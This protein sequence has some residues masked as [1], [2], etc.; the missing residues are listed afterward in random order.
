MFAG[1][2]VLD[3]EHHG[4]GQGRHQGL[5]DGFHPGGEPDKGAVQHPHGVRSDHQDG[6]R[7][8]GQSPVQAVQHPTPRPAAPPPYVVV[9]GHPA[10][11]PE[12]V[13]YRAPANP[14]S[15]GA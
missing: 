7:R 14:S 5:E 11:D 4:Q 12:I 15:A 1:L 2:G 13:S 6:Q 8:G 10:S 3:D 9:V